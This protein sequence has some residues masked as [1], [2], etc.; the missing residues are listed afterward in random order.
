VLTPG[1]ALLVP[2]VTGEPPP[3][4]AASTGDPWFC[5]PWTLLGAPALAVPGPTGATGAPIGVQIVMPSGADAPL[6]RAGA[7]AVAALN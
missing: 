5:R 7:W 4:R 2:A 6:L 3:L 1:E